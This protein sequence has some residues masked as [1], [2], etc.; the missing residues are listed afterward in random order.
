MRRG[1]GF[2]IA[3]LG[4]TTVACGDDQAPVVPLRGVAEI[5]S[6]P[7]HACALLVDGSVACWGN[8]YSGQ[9]GDGTTRDRH[10]AVKVS[11]VSGAVAVSANGD[12]SCAL[13]DGGSV[14]CWGMDYVDEASIAGSGLPPHEID[15]LAK[16]SSI[17]VGN[18]YHACAAHGEA[19]GE[20]SCWGRNRFGQLGD[21]TQE[22]SVTPVRALELSLV[23]GVAANGFASCAVSSDGSVACWGSGVDGVAGD[24]IDGTS[25]PMPVPELGDAVAVTLGDF[26][27]CALRAGGTVSCWGRNHELELGN[28]AAE[29]TSRTPVTVEGLSD[30][31]GVS[32]GFDHTC[33]VRADGS[34]WC[35][36]GN[37]DGRQGTGEEGEKTLAA[38]VRGIHSAISVGVGWSS[39]CAVL[40]N[41]TARC[42]GYNDYGSLGDGTTT[43]SFEPVTVLER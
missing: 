27:A 18:S 19:N 35:W 8:N 4:M 21:G 10:A 9:L 20:V 12:S 26:H 17:S 11:G 7:N 22:D 3:W 25:T 37:E 36:G 39:T 5:S 14:V 41:H 24:S 16:I 23:A 30:A 38:P 13:L 1:V 40:A 31:T 32:A 43:D 29:T 6:G 28:A 34:V 15:G 2:L 33:A 42:W